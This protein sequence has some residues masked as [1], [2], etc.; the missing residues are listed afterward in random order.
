MELVSIF[1]T[2]SSV[3]NIQDF[4][5]RVMRSLVGAP[6]ILFHLD[7]HGGMPFLALLCKKQVILH[8][9]RNILNIPS[10]TARNHQ[11]FTFIVLSNN[12]E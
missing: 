1:Y 4:Y 5:G 9:K 12:L 11:F 7:Y 3:L 6:C 8:K 10:N 2:S